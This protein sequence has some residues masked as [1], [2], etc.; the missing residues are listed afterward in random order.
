MQ[1]PLTPQQI[2]QNMAQTY[3]TC[4]FYR[5]EGVVTTV[6][7]GTNGRG[8]FQ[9]RKPFSTSFVRPAGLFRF[10]YQEDDKP[11][12]PNPR[13]VIWSNGREV[14]SW[15]TIRPVVQK[16]PSLEMAIAGATGVSGGSAN[17]V[18]SLLLQIAFGQMLKHLQGFVPAARSERV[19]GAN[20]WRVDAKDLRGFPVVVWV[21]KNTFLVRRLFQR[22]NLGPQSGIAE[23]TTTY[24]PSLNV[25]FDPRVFETGVPKP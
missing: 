6:F 21:D 22:V 23:T 9:T 15:W 10:E 24:K 19:G 20:C 7:K 11:N 5:D 8:T 13:Y 1:P 4:R 2:L 3:A 18:P 25:T 17:T 12:G 16:M 14:R